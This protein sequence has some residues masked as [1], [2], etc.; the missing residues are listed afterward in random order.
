MAA[1]RQAPAR[2]NRASCVVAG[3][4]GERDPGIVDGCEN[5]H[6]IERPAGRHHATCRNQPEARLQPDD[7]VEHCRHA[8]G[9][10]GIGAERDRHDAG[11]DR[12]RRARTR[13]ARNK[14][15]AQRITRNRIGRAHANQAGGELIEIGLA[16]DN[17]AGRPQFG[18]GGCVGCRPVG[19]GRARRGGRQPATSIL[20]FTAIGT[21]KKPPRVRSVV[22]LSASATAS[23]SSR[24]AMKIPGSASARMR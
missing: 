22:S 21:P 1:M 20:S 17:G 16:D 6:A 18:D 24:S 19:E 11:R 15:G 12:D 2:A 3:G 14:I 8:S 10:G 23:A 9:P 5:R 7:I 13:S 4:G